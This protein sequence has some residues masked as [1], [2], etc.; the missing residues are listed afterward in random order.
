M[1]IDTTSSWTELDSH[2]HELKDSFPYWQIWKD[3]ERKPINTFSIAYLVGH[4]LS[5]VEDH[6]FSTLT[7]AVMTRGDGK[8]KLWLRRDLAPYK[9]D[10]TLF[11]EL[12]HVHHPIYLSRSNG[13]F[14]ASAEEENAREAITEW[15]GRKARADPGLLRLAVLSFGLDA[16]IYDKSSYRA[17]QWI[18]GQQCFSFMDKEYQDTWMD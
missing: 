8:A 14:S 4:G 6:T 3:I 10:V 18:K 2:V 12:A 11:H 16:Y 1:I 5:L 15:L 9:R 17:F 7:G 13:R